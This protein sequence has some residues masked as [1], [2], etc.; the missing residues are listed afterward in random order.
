[1]VTEQE[2]KTAYKEL[3]EAKGTFLLAADVLEGLKTELERANA[4]ALYEGIIEGKNEA[5]RRGAALI[6]FRAEYQK[7]DAARNG[8][9]Q[10]KYHFELA[11]IEVNHV[12]AIIRVNEIAVANQAS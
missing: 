3:K 4:K 6:L 1:M 5:Q 10:A 8:Y 2:V 12:R 9:D 7:F 11:T